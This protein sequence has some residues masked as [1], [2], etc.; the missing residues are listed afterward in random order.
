MNDRCPSCGHRLTVDFGTGEVVCEMCGVISSVVEESSANMMTSQ[1]F[2]PP[3][4]AKELEVYHLIEGVKGRLSLND[5]VVREAKHVAES[6]ISEGVRCSV[7]ELSYFSLYVACRPHN[8]MLCEKILR[9]FQLMG[10][11]IDKKSGM[12]VLTKFWRFYKYRRTDMKLYLRT[13][14]QDVKSNPYIDNYVKILVGVQGGLLW[15]KIYEFSAILLKRCAFGGASLKV[16]TLACLSVA[17]E[18]IFNSFG[19]ENPVSLDF[20]SYNF[21]LNRNNLRK[22]SES[23]AVTFYEDM[24]K[25]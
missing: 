7:L 2:L 3:A 5:A 12:K 1:T 14:I 11:K 19:V 8:P 13:I 25:M 23:V 6:I 18:K 22:V 10:L 24:A 4:N 17:C 21:N 9:E 20:L 15:A 16:R